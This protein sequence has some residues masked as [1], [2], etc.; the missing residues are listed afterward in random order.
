MLEQERPRIETV[1][2]TLGS[3]VKS[4]KSIKVLKYK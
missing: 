4:M 2:E 3:I 1:H